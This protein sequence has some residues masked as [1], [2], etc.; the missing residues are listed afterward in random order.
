VTG[1]PGAPVPGA[2]PVAAAEVAGDGLTGLVEGAARRVYRGVA[3]L[4]R[5]RPW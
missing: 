3:A 5:L 1:A 4:G 2:A